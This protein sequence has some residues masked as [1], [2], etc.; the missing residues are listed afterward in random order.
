MDLPEKSDAVLSQ[1]TRARI[2]ELLA[3]SARPV[4]TT[5]LA[6]QLGLHPNGVRAHLDRMLQAGLVERRRDAAGRGRPRDEWTLSP[7]ARPGGSPPT[8]YSDLVRWLARAYPAGTESL[9]RIEA[10]GREAGRDAGRKAAPDGSSSPAEALAVTLTAFGFQPRVTGESDE[11][12]TCCLG[13]CP[14]REAVHENQLVVC[15]L[16]RGLT[17]GLLETLEPGFRLEGFEPRDPDE[18]GCV[19]TAIRQT[20]EPC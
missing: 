17:G 15:G 12:F 9:R 20:G 2:F 4:P 6:D 5:W 18:A 8:A 19:I 3:E 16:H 13:N 11:G 1:P 10:V 7:D 14:Y